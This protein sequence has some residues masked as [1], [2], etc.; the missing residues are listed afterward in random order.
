MSPSAS[1]LGRR[2]GRRGEEEGDGEGGEAAAAIPGAAAARRPT[3]EHADTEK[4][5]SF[6]PG[7]SVEIDTPPPREKRKRRRGE[8]NSRRLPLQLRGEAAAPAAAAGE[9]RGCVY[10]ALYSGT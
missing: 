2:C 4:R 1:S 3:V 8:R 7:E 10:N 5:G 9:G 6:T